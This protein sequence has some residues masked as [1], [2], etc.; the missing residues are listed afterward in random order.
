MTSLGVSVVVNALLWIAAVFLFPPEDA[1]ATLHYSIDVG[2]DF[3]G[4]SRQ[5]IV[6]PAIGAALAAGNAVLGGMVWPASPL[7]ARML[8]FTTPALQLILSASFL[9]IWRANL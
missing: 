7:T 9:L 5:I 4:A 3:I 6:L 1:A 8:W 2:I